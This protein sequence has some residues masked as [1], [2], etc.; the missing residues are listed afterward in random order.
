MI[1]TNDNYFSQEANLEYMSVSQFKLFETCSAAAMAELR[2]EY[3]RET[4]TS[5]L[6]GTY[7]DARFDGTL[8][9]FKTNHPEMYKRDGSLKAEYIQ[10]EQIINRIERDTLFMKYMSGEKQV[11]MTGNISGIKV[12]I[13]IDSLLPDRIVDMKIMKDFAPVFVEGQGRLPWFEAWRYDLQGAIYQEIVRQN[14]GKKLP[15]YL[16]AATKEKV[17]DIG[18]FLIE[19]ELL[20][21]ELSQ[22]KTNAPVYDAMK[23]GILEPERCEHCNYC[24]A[25][26]VLT[27]ENIVKSGDLINE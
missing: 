3:E 5:L 13:K 17:P 24:K 6:V 2:G 23:K 25:T 14:T 18:I 9:V 20:E 19:D 16:A 22:F 11:I 10:A 4:T 1:L 26:K 7:A 15:F 8:D 12:K 27:N 21:Y